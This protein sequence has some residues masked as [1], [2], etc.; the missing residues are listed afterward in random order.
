MRDVVQ[1]EVERDGFLCFSLLGERKFL[2]GKLK[3][4]DFLQEHSVVF[5]KEEKSHHGQL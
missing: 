1:I 4:I 5:E 3:N 2:K